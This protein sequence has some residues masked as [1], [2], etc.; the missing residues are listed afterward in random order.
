MWTTSQVWEKMSHDAETW[1]RKVKVGLMVR[2]VQQI[3]ISFPSSLKYWEQLSTCCL[4][5]SFWRHSPT[6]CLWTHQNQINNFQTWEMSPSDEP[7]NA[8]SP[9]GR[10]SKGKKQE[11]CIEGRG[12]LAL[13][14]NDG[15]AACQIHWHRLQIYVSVAHPCIFSIFVNYWWRREHIQMQVWPPKSQLWG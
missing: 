13:I 4:N 12:W 6:W 3:H 1:W 15:P 5:T 2:N 7:V 14:K 11:R 9:E 10:Q 8:T